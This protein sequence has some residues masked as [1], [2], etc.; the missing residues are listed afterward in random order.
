MYNEDIAEIKEQIAQVS[1]ISAELNSAKYQ[2]RI[3]HRNIVITI[4]SILL[5]IAISFIIYLLVAHQK[6]TETSETVTTTTFENVEQTA[7]NGG[8][9]Q[10]I[11]GDYNADNTE[12]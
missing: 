7:D 4:E 3:Y 2:K 11:G 10:V 9:N 1:R 12:N 8:N 5:T 6:V